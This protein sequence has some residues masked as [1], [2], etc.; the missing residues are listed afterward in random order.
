MFDICKDQLLHLNDV[1][2]RELVAR[3]CEA[4]LSLAGA[5]VS[6]VRWGGSHTTP[7]GG[8]DVE[9]R[10]EGQ[11]F[12]GDFV[13]RAWTGIQVKKPKMP[14]GKII[15]GMSPKGDLRPIFQE[16]ARD[17]GC[18]IIVSLADDPTGPQ[19]ATRKKTM[20]EQ[21]R[22]VK[23]LGNLRT[24][25]YGC[26]DLATWLRQHPSVQ[27]W[28]REKLGLQLSGWRPHGRWST[29]PQG[30]ED[31]LICEA[32]VVIRLPRREQDKLGIA[33]GIDEIREL[34]RNSEKAV[35]IV[36]LSGVGKS[37]I[38]QALFE[39]TVGNEPLD[40]HLA[41]YAD[42]GEAPDPPARAVLER[43]A[44]KRRPAIMV[45]DNCPSGVHNRI[46][47]QVASSPNLRLVTVEYDVRE[48]NPEV[49]NVVR[50][51]AEGPEIAETLIKRRHP[52]LGQLNARRIAELSEGNARVALALADAASEVKASLSSFSDAQLFERLF[53]QRNAPGT[54]LLEAAEVLSLVYSFSISPDEEGVDE[55][56]TLASLLDQS[57]LALHR[58]AQ[59]LVDRQLA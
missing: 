9:I 42:L 35:R 53:Y 50:I 14:R 12:A 3:L 28:V 4:E 22:S 43:L 26:N 47:N 30:V 51:D 15:E 18:Y 13:P 44:A 19:L 27:L 59:T 46:A 55:L 37:R 11:E 2:L 38:V 58:S 49:T 8:L 21:I 7:D 32:G 5:P 33:Q 39:E 34:V 10:V 48:D 45:L 6:A 52:D 54:D 20:Q 57:R 41:V 31:G 17:N 29:I 25:F 56:A 24:K 40:R 1:E 16:L 36:G 23:N